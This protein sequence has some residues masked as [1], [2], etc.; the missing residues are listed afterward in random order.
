MKGRLAW[1]IA[2]AHVVLVKLPA[3]QPRHAGVA[4]SSSSSCAVDARLKSATKSVSSILLVVLV[5]NG[6]ES[7][8]AAAPSTSAWVGQRPFHLGGGWG[9][10]AAGQGGEGQ[11]CFKT[12]LCWDRSKAAWRWCLRGTAA[13]WRGEAVPYLWVRAP[14]RALGACKALLDGVNL[15]RVVD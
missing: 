14:R 6:L 7:M 2:S 1:C 10:L 15:V 4:S 11:Q 8:G 13:G 5:L 3:V 9:A 12:G